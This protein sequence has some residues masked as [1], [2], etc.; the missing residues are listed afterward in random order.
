MNILYD[1]HRDDIECAGPD[2]LIN[3]HYVL[4]FSPNSYFISC[5]LQDYNEPMGFLAEEK[6]FPLML[7]GFY[8]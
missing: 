1:F 4:H 5:H 8:K 3:W 7:F 2:V 6:L